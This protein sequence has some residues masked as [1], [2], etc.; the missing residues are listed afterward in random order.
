MLYTWLTHVAV[1]HKASACRLCIAAHNCARS[2]SHSALLRNAS[3][4]PHVEH[5][6]STYIRI[7]RNAS[8]TTHVFY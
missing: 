8:P 1:Q 7:P 6:G 3:P 2:Q 5:S 4:I